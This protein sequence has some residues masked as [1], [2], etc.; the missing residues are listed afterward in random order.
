MRTYSSGMSARLKFAI[1]TA[2]SHDVLLIDEALATGDA[3]FA[4]RSEEKVQELRAGAGTVILVS[5]DI[6]TVRGA[7]ERT[8]WLEGGELVLDGPSDEVCDAY[9]AYVKDPSSFKAPKHRASH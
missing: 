7:C 9:E 8:I 6:G 1:A 4:K 3:M 5:H 2:K